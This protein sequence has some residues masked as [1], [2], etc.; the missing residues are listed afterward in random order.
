MERRRP[1]LRVLCGTLWPFQR[2][3]SWVGLGLDIV[4][5]SD[6]LVNQAGFEAEV[7]ISPLDNGMH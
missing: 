3:V 1:P 7:L 5:S 4:F 6:K 2:E